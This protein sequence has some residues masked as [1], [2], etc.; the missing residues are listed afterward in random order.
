VEGARHACLH[1]GLTNT[2]CPPALQAS[3]AT[4]TSTV[5]SAERRVEEA[6]SVVRSYEHVVGAK[7]LEIRRCVY[8][9]SNLMYG[10]IPLALHS[11]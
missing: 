9:S 2:D 8:K 4:S 11:Q 3:A 1:K 10:S 7:R 6:M 5:I